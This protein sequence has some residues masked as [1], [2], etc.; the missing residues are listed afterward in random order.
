MSVTLGLRIT[1]PALF[2]GHNFSLK[3]RSDDND[4]IIL[5]TDSQ[6]KQL[7]RDH[8]KVCSTGILK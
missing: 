1:R 4:K 2:F 5:P 3:K 6:L 7:W 8:D